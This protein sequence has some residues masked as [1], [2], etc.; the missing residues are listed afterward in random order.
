[1]DAIWR[2]A[3]VV[4]T[5]DVSSGRGTAEILESSTGRIAIRRH[6]R[7]SGVRT[8]VS[9]REVHRDG[10]VHLE[11]LTLATANVILDRLRD[12][13]FEGDCFVFHSG[14]EPTTVKKSAQELR[15]TSS[16]VKFARNRD[17]MA[18]YRVGPPFTTVIS[19]HV[20]P[21]GACNLKCPYCSVT[22]R[23][24]KARLHL[25]VI[26]DYLSKLKARGLRG[27]ILTGG[28]EPTLYREFNEL[29][30][31]AK[32]ELGLDIGLITNGTQ[33][34][35]VDPD[36]WGALSWVRVSVNFFDNWEQ[37][38]GIPAE[39][40]ASDCV[41]GCSVVLT[42]EHEISIRSSPEWLERLGG[43][44]ALADRVGADYIRL[45]PNCSLPT[46]SLLA[47][48]SWIER[49][50]TQLDDGR[51]FQQHKMHRRPA[52]RTCHQAYFRPYL[53]EEPFAATGVP[54]SVYP[55]DSVVLND[56]VGFFDSKYQICAPEDILEFM[57]GRLTMQ[58]EP[59]TD[60][61]QCVFADNVE[62]LEL[63]RE[64]GELG[65]DVPPDP[66]LHEQFP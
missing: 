15:V 34:A 45:L 60:C 58:F 28:G 49:L 13:T 31:W 46:S 9:E 4:R 36:A 44:K 16:A 29:V 23:D 3:L 32:H 39:H 21:E 8:V 57:D 54:G 14:E 43:V 56:G 62:M 35:R 30:T 2:H 38:I 20:S 50:V 22:Y 5:S 55:C 24:T 17:Q 51:F 19:T 12:A 6:A 47:Q 33:A 64:T 18:S 52:A 63:W 1:M 66:V 42:S 48:H 7:R 26:Q 37:S 53:S 27:L 25:D 11:P 59:S 61:S 10:Q 40:L 41:V 65:I